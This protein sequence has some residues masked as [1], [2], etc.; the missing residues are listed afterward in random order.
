MSTPDPN[1]RKG[2]KR[3]GLIDWRNGGILHKSPRAFQGRVDG[4]PLL[5]MTDVRMSVLATLAVSATPYRHCRL[6]ELL[7]IPN[8]NPVVR[9]LVNSGILTTWAPKRSVKLLAL[10]P[11]HPC[12]EPLRRLL[13]RIA[14]VYSFPRPLYL[15]ENM[16][17]GAAPVR[18]SRRRD[19]RL[20]FGTPQRTLVLLAVYLLGYSSMS[21]ICRA[22]SIFDA[23]G[24]NRALWRFHAFGVLRSEDRGGSIGIFFEL[25]HEF[26]FANELRDVLEAMEFALP[27]W[28]DAITRYP[29][30]WRP[31]TSTRRLRAATPSDTEFRQWSKTPRSS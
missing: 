4:P 23:H 24:L 9:D 27:M 20:T 22:L 6:E 15:S 8:L 3:S 12:Y 14:D 10:D 31:K 25:N 5:F 30:T 26:A 19:A 21:D 1:P 7:G 18:R 2:Y 13:I 11:C 29:F 17:G 16:F 28:T